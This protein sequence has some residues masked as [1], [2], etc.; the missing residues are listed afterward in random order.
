M[1]R[2]IKLLFGRCRSLLTSL[3]QLTFFFFF[4]RVG[5]D[6]RFFH[7]YMRINGSKGS[8]VDKYALTIGRGTNQRLQMGVKDLAPTDQSATS[9]VGVW[10]SG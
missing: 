3:T 7:T 2:K 8:T 4:F 10:I 6:L 9:V 1:R 5:H